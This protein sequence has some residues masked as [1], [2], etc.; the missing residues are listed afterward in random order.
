VTT[1]FVPTGPV[2]AADTLGVDA[3]AVV[4][5]AEAD[6]AGFLIGFVVAVVGCVLDVATFAAGALFLVP[7]GARVAGFA[8]VADPEA[9][10]GAIDFFEAGVVPVFATEEVFFAGDA[11]VFWGVLVEAG[12]FTGVFVTKA[13]FSGASFVLFVV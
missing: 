5:L 10:F 3:F 12:F 2:E 4:S 1:F 11:I 6:A 9:A 7:R 8:G 13:F